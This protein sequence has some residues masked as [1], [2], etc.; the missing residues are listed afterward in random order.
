MLMHHKCT[1]TIEESAFLQ[2]RAATQAI[3]TPRFLYNNVYTWRNTIR[4]PDCAS[5]LRCCK[6]LQ[7]RV[8]LNR[9]CTFVV[10]QHGRQHVELYGNIAEVTAYCKWSIV[11]IMLLFTTDR[12]SYSLNSVWSCAKYVLT[13]NTLECLHHEKGFQ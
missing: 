8:F 3:S 2:C 12:T 1:V 9:H 6:T 10:H 11:H 13:Q 7:K 5:C 4:M